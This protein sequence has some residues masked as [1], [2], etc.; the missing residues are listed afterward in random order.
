MKRE[1]ERYKLRERNNKKERNRIYFCYDI[2]WN[3]EVKRVK[4]PARIGGR[5]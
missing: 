4:I 2:I 3:P 1:R 5:R